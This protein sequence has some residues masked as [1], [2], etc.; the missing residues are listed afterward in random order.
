MCLMLDA[1]LSPSD[2]ID[3]ELNFGFSE[4]EV[5]SKYDRNE[6]RVNSE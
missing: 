6:I 4:V 5:K 3:A 1:K 2:D